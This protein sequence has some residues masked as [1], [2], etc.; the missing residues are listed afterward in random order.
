MNSPSGNQLDDILIVDD[1]LPNLKLLSQMLTER[2]FQVRAAL[3]GTRA[4]AAIQASPPD[5][6]L[7]DVVMPEMDGY[8]LCQR[9]KA[10]EYTRDIPV[11][12]ISSL[13]E[14][15]DKVK[16]FAV[17]GLD[18]ITKPFQLEE[19]LARIETHL[20]LRHLQMEVRAQEEITRVLLNASS[21][22]AI[23]TRTDGTII[24][25]NE[26]AA[27]ELGQQTSELAQ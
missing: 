7:L 25:L 20:K 18:Y 4:L 24:T 8:E 14:T 1:T 11:L 22:S 9:L 23:L 27:Q 17:G 16:G 5:L 12:F 19:V 26:P 10:D 2:G 6:I 13:S 3:N 15:E 21:D